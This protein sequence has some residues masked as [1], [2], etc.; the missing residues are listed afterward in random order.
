MPALAAILL[1]CMQPDSA[2]LVSQ[3]RRAQAEFERVRM[4]LL[5]PGVASSGGRCDARIGRFCYWSGGGSAE[6]PREPAR[7][8]RE[9]ARLLAVLDGVALALPGDGWVAGQRVRY[10]LEA[11]HA[12]AATDA[13]RACRAT[14]W[15]CAA[16]QGLA[17]HEAGDYGSA[18]R[19]FDA[20]LSEMPDD[21]QCRWTD[22]SDLLE[23][24]L[25]GRYRRLACGERRGLEAR[26]WWL[27]QPLWSSRG[28]DRRT[29]HYARVTMARL[30][31]HARSPYGL[32][33]DDERELI[34]RYGWPAA[35]ERDD[36]GGTREP[37]Y[38]GH[39]PEP[40]FHFLPDARGFDDPALG[41][42]PGLLDSKDALERYA[43][44]YA[45]R[46]L[47]LEPAFATFR[48]GDSTLVVATWDVSGDTAFQGSGREAALVLA[49]E[50]GSLPVVERRAAARLEGALVAQAPWAPTLLSLELREPERRVAA[51]GR[52]PALVPAAGVV[53]L[54]GILLFEPGDSLPADLPAALER[55]HAGG[56]R[57]GQRIGLYWEGYGLAAEADLS[58]AVTVTPERSSWLR[59]FAAAVGLARRRGRVRVEWRETAQP[60]RGRTARALV[61]DLKGLDAGRYRID[62]TV[63][64]R[65]GAPAVATRRLDVIAN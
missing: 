51:R 42:E 27:A 30:L 36:G 10:L 8:G 6:L 19:S 12:G 61:L 56:V 41:D 15:W 60:T 58:T 37:V 65:G 40:S 32:W 50:P 1:L 52:A 11:G 45:A 44:P 47:R 54:S 26:V 25:R 17:E 24:P 20:A 3:A 46:F 64:S 29:E 34:V 16:L 55:V 22:L 14:A 23:E 33:G 63:T 43:P 7:I 62:V 53:A 48:R 31:Q 13:A 39:E 35:W 28:N 57:L 2:A 18:E 38:I 9:R 59:R 49:R 5:P 21:E 4:F